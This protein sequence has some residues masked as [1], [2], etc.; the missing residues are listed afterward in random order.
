MSRKLSK[1][2]PVRLH[3]TTVPRLRATA[4]RFRLIPAELIR[5]A[6]D[7]KLAEWEASE[8]ITVST[9]HQQN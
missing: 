2:T 6:L 3:E 4:R 5:I 9:I 7:Q 8:V 1:P